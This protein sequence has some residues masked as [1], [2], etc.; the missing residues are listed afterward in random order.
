MKIKRK[1]TEKNGSYPAYKAVE[2]TIRSLF[3]IEKGLQ[4]DPATVVH[5][6][7]IA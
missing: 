6:Q 2:V 1:T 7:K 3:E 5:G 4:V